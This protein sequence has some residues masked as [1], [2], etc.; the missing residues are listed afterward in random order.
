MESLESC[1]GAVKK[2]LPSLTLDAIVQLFAI[3]PAQIFNQEL[4]IIAE[5]ADALLTLFVPGGE[6]VFRKEQ[7][8]SISTNNAF[9]G[10]QLTGRTI[11]VVQGDQFK[12]TAQ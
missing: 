12:I 3:A 9:I 5:G 1:F 2:A 10:H 7:V 8:A 4:P 11:G 6:Q